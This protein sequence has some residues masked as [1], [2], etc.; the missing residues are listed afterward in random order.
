M[1][2]IDLPL[3]LSILHLD[4]VLA[5]GQ[6]FVKADPITVGGLD[7]PVDF[8]GISDMPVNPDCL[9]LTS[10]YHCIPVDVHPEADALVPWYPLDDF[11]ALDIPQNDLSIL[12]CRS[13]E[14]LAIQY[15]EAATH[16]KFLVEMPLVG[17]LDA[18]RNVVP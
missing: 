14:G 17:F 2:L 13:Y 12:A 10:A 8:C 3:A 16:G 11:L 1:S 9:I 6:L 7:L 5:N 18:S 15:T 4:I